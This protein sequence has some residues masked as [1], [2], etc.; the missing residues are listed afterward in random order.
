[1][2]LKKWMDFKGWTEKEEK[3]RNKSKDGEKEGKGK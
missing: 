1:M 2:I 3:R